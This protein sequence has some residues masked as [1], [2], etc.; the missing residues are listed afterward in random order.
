MTGGDVS[1][2][3]SLKRAEVGIAMGKTRSDVAKDACEVVSTNYSFASILNA[4][5]QG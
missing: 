4:I 2:S 1:E 5:G 3:P